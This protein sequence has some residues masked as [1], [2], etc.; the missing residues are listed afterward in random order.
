V[1][2]ITTQSRFRKLDWGNLSPGPEE[3]KFIDGLDGSLEDSWTKELLF[4]RG[5]W[6]R[7]KDSTFTIA[8][9]DSS[10][11]ER[12][13][14]VYTRSEL[15]SESPY[16]GHSRFAWRVENLAPPRFP[17][18][19]ELRGVPFKPGRTPQFP[20]ART[21]ARLDLV[22]STNPF[23]TFTTPDLRGPGALKVTWSLLPDDPIF[24]PVTFVPPEEVPATCKD[25][26]GQDVPCAFGLEPRLNF[27]RPRN[28]Q[29]FEPGETVHTYVDLRDS[30]GNRLHAPDLL[31]SV[32]ELLEDK[33]NGVMIT[34]LPY[35]ASTTEADSTPMVTISGPLHRM[36]V[37][38][39]PTEAPPFFA[40]EHS[41]PFIEDL[42]TSH[43]GPTLY[44]TKVPTR[45]S[46]KLPEDAEPGTY[47]ALIKFSRYFM[48][49]RISKLEPFFFQVG[50]AKR[51]KYPDQVGNCQICHRGVLS[52]DNL[53][54]GLSVDHIESCK[55]C[56]LYGDDQIGRIQ[57]TVHRIHMRSP[58]YTVDKKDCTICHLTQQSATRPSIAVC[59][60]CHPSVHDSQYFPMRFTQQGT[61]N[62]F[63]NCAQSCHVAQLPQNHI[64]PSPQ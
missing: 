35:L 13:S 40:R 21:I 12:T 58:R 6:Q 3:W 64:L 61:P 27:A 20:T 10:G 14:V 18:D 28:G 22:G 24:F 1:R 33:G 32:G 42:G 34:H 41:F 52:L 49:E 38:S 46:R 9:L 31:P 4:E 43:I 60:S 53:R 47:V 62:R 48:G 7:T 44:S 17:G 5:N 54:H 25:D 16:A 30:L 51:T 19:T 23:K 29:Y 50:S 56:H 57:E 2:W 45:F 15:L 11:T 36:Q 26:N 59:S 8:V 63:G 55:A 37:H 39:D